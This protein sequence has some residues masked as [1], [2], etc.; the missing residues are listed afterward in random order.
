[1]V[2]MYDE[3][4]V[5][6]GFEY[7]TEAGSSR[8][9]YLYNAQ[10]DVEGLM[11]ETGFCLYYY[12]YD[13]WGRLIQIVDDGGYTV[14]GESLAHKNPIRYRGYIYDNETGFYYLKSRYY[15][16]VVSRF[17]SPD[18]QINA[19]QGPLGM[20][21]YAYCLNNPVNR[22]DITGNKSYKNEWAEVFTQEG[23]T[24][25]VEHW[26]KDELL[27][28]YSFINKPG[29]AVE[30]VYINVGDKHHKYYVD[31]GI[32]RYYFSG[33]NEKYGSGG[34]IK[35]EIMLANAMYRSMKAI[36]P[37]Y[38]SGRTARGLA[39]E[40]NLHRYGNSHPGIIALIYDVFN[41]KG[42]FAEK[43]SRADMGATTEKMVDYD[44][45]AKYFEFYSIFYF[46]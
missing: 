33:Y 40:L 26:E 22:V 18:V 28:T 27:F 7:I 20:N 10:G 46:V 38:L 36:N 29:V 15:D 14:T 9:Y 34:K 11:D 5:P 12:N 1:M 8:Y 35:D 39:C 24:L 43:C 31:N 25:T 42:E 37:N 2:I 16:P 30:E 44:P 13:A 23:D 19:D 21:I 4:G 45:N 6:Y 17:I 3:S 32:I 41:E